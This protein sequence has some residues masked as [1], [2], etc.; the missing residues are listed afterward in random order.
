MLLLLPENINLLEE[1]IFKMCERDKIQ[2]KKQIVQRMILH[3]CTKYNEESS[4][5]LAKTNKKI[6]YE[7]MEELKQEESNNQFI[8]QTRTENIVQDR[9][10]DLT[11]HD[12]NDVKNVKHET[13]RTFFENN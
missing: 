12:L 5:N 8:R 11:K 4:I 3:L 10:I 2:F 6:V 7:I 1:I 13:P 9:T